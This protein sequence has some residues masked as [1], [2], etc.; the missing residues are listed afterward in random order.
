MA[1]GPLS[2]RIRAK[3]EA[4]EAENAR[5]A[6]G[7]TVIRLPDLLPPLDATYTRMVTYL[8]A[9]CTVTLIAPAGIWPES[10]GQSRASRTARRARCQP[11]CTQIKGLMARTGRL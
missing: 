5:L 10:S 2:P 7:N 1:S 3:L 8:V 9:T 11:K 6:H 4:A